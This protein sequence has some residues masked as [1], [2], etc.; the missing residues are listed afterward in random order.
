M[1]RTMLL[2]VSGHEKLLV[3]IKNIGRENSKNIFEIN[4]VC[5]SI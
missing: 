5:W 1:M 3:V 4:I 2:E